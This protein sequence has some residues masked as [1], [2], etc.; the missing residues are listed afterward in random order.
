MPTS[1]TAPRGRF[2]NNQQLL[3]LL[4]HVS[5]LT[6]YRHHLHETWSVKA[7]PISG[8]ATDAIPYILP[9]SAPYFALFS[10]GTEQAMVT[11]LPAKIPAEP[12]PAI[13]RPMINAVE[14]GAAPQ[15]NEPTSKIIMDTEYAHLRLKKVKN[16]LHNNWHEQVV[17]K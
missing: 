8:Q 6:M 11:K 4:A 2:C 16:R 5:G 3:L 13:A 14:F 10:S 7:P 9:N 12:T 1:T 17:R 15:I